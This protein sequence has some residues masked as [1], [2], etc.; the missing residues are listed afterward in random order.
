MD[1][2]DRVGKLRRL[3]HPLENS[4]VQ[5]ALHDA[6]AEIATPAALHQ[7]LQGQRPETERQRCATAFG[8]RLVVLLAKRRPPVHVQVGRRVLRLH[9]LDQLFFQQLLDLQ[10]RPVLRL[11]HQRGVQH[12]QVELLLQ[13]FATGHFHPYRMAGQPLSQALGPGQHQRVA[14]AHLRAEG[15]Q[16][17]TALRQRQVAPRGFPG[18]HQ[19]SGI[20]DEA[21]TVIGQPRPGPIAYEQ[22]ATQLLLEVVHP[23]GHRRLGDVQAFGGGDETAAA[24]DLEKGAGEI[25]VHGWPSVQ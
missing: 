23:C 15:Q 12:A 6:G 2:I 8:Q 1:Q 21:L 3:F 25:D 11:V 13:L 9:H 16:L 24:N 22:P 4:L 10:A 20:G 19:L 18:L 5:I 14:Q 7:V 17:V